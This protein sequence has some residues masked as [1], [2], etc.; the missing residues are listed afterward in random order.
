MVRANKKREREHAT[1]NFVISLLSDS[2]E[3]RI[4]PGEPR[5]LLSIICHQHRILRLMLSNM[6]RSVMRCGKSWKHFVWS[7][8]LT[9][10][11]QFLDVL[12][13]LYVR[14]GI[15][16]TNDW[17]NAYLQLSYLMK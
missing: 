9:G 5:E 17:T 14:R 4:Q 13:W 8:E 15:P 2:N 1:K 7:G 3:R 12:K 10:F 6:Q 11:H 16:T